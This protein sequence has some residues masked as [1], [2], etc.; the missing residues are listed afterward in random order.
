MLILQ[1]EDTQKFKLYQIILNGG[2]AVIPCDTIYGFV[3]LAPLVRERLNIIKKRKPE[4]DYLQLIKKKWLPWITNQVIETELLTLCPGNLTFV[5][6]NKGGG[7]TA[8]RFP[9]DSMLNYLLDKLQQPLYSTSVNRSGQRYLYKVR[10]ILSEFEKDIDAFIDAG[11]LSERK[12][13][14]ILDVTSKPYTIIRSGA[15]YVPENLLME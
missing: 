12:P 14:T 3:G 9:V 2:I 10:D 1:E 13:S 4:K 6:K 5:V 7:T 15:C 11:D 8:V